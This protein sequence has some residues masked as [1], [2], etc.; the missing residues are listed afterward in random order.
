MKDMYIFREG[1]VALSRGASKIS[2]WRTGPRHWSFELLRGI[3]RSREAVVLDSVFCT[4]E[5]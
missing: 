2:Y 1:H 5:K 3:L 4:C